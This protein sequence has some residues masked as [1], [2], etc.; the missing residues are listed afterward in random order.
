VAVTDA[1]QVGQARRA[2]AALALQLGF[3]ETE[4]G[5]VALT[6]TEAASN[7]VKH[8]GGGEIVLRGLED[9]IEILALDRGPGMADL[10]RCLRDGFSTAGS[11][12]T[13]LG[14]I[15]RL[16]GLFDAYTRPQG[17]TT[18]LCRL[19]ARSGADRTRALAVGAVHL[20]KAGEAICGDA[21]AVDERPGRGL[22]LVAD[23]LGHGPAAAAAA[24]EAVRIFRE[25]A[26]LDPIEIV[27]RAHDALR[28]T[29][30]AAVAVAE[31]DLAQRLLRFAG[32][33]NV[34]GTIF[35]EGASRSLISH[36]GTVGHG[37]RKVQVFEYPFPDGALL[38]MHSDGLSTH[39]RLDQYPAL[40]ARHPGLVAGVLYRDF[41]RGHDDVTVV[42]VRGE[43]SA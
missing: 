21:W 6:V 42:A 36:N 38:V 32:V 23:G 12:G 26:A 29:R 20:P 16:S 3:D 33:G 43:G 17:G 25:S 22:I 13:G 24:Q 1:S 28:A 5:K 11:P 10:D 9:G 18:L 30:G 35:A 31:L 27:R 19:W 14:A 34:A 37:L 40:A 7:L 8:A 15:T 41:T 4:G 2:A 39:W